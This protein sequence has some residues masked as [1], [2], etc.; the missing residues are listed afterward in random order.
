MPPNV[1]CLVV[2]LNMLAKS[3]SLALVC[4]LTVNAAARQ[5]PSGG[6]G[7]LAGIVSDPLGV[8]APGA[9]IVIKGRRLRR[10][11]R[12]GGD[13]TYSV[14]L[15]PGKYSVRVEHPGFVP[16]RKRVRITRDAVTRLDVLFRLDPKNTVTIHAARAAGAPCRWRA[17]GETL[18]GE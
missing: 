12:S 6:D 15:P 18:K 8:Y 3:L 13:G 5:T 11:L 4:C 7:R 17:S 9:R 10:E 2:R 16:I 14:D 1:S